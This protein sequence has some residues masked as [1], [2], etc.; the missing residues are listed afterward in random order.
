MNVNVVEQRA[1][2][3]ICVGMLDAADGVPVR[4]ID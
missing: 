4:L 3:R 1:H 2:Q